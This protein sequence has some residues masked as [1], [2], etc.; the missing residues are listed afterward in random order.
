MISFFGFSDTA[1]EFVITSDWALK[2][3]YSTSSFIRRRGHVYFTDVYFQ[4]L[5]T[6]TRQLQRE[7]VD[8][9]KVY[10]K[11]KRTLIFIL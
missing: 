2:K 10:W 3:T 7:T 8:C 9:I 6:R 1:D 4:S 11:L 5:S